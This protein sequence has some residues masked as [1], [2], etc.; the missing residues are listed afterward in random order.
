MKRIGIIGLG[1]FGS[2]LANKFSSSHGVEVLGIDSDHEAV[3]RLSNVITRS[4]EGD[5]TD[6]E[7]LESVGFGKCDLVM[8]AIGNMADNLIATMH[9]KKLG[10]KKIISRA[11][12]EA[13]G[14]LLELME[15]VVVVYPYKEYADKLAR[16]AL[17]TGTVDLKEFAD[18]FAV[19]EIDAPEKLVGKSLRESEVRQ[20]YGVTVLCANRVPAENPEAHRETIFL[21]ADDV[22]APDDK[23]V[24]YGT[25]DKIEALTQ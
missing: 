23:L 3:Q 10:A 17:S 21:Q 9:C 22:I 14:E 20:N 4:I 7:V 18:G 15:S 1:R 12:S 11:D 25:I 16:M 5:A 19:A 13:H 6:R 2:S 24:V 8:V